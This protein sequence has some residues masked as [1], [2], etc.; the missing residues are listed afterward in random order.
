MGVKNKAG[1]DLSASGSFEITPGFS[2]VLVAQSLV[3][4]VVFCRQ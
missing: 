2:R 1:A 3:Y 4:Y